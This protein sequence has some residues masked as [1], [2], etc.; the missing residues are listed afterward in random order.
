MPRIRSIKPDFC[1]SERIA[2]PTGLSIPCRLHFAM[3]WTYCDDEGRGVDNPRLIKAALWPLDDEITAVEVEA[4]QVELEAKGR[5]R[6]YEVDGR[7]CFVTTNFKEHQKPS[8]PQPSKLPEPPQ[9]GCTPPPEG[10]RNGS[11]KVPEGIVSDA[12]KA[13]LDADLG[14]L[15]DD[16]RNALGGLLP[17]VVGEKERVSRGEGS[18]TVPATA[19]VLALVVDLAEPPPAKPGA[20]FE[21]TTWDLFWQRWP[22]KVQKQNAR[23]AWCAVA[24]STGADIGIIEGLDRWLRHWQADAT[25]ERFIPHPD[26]WLRERRWLEQPPELTR[27]QGQ[28][29]A[30]AQ[31]RAD[32]VAAYAQAVGGPGPEAIQ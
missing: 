3:L 5:I 27:R 19:P 25:P 16:S 13:Q 6:R 11:G 23:K 21:Q 28:A 24:S 8:K 17:V 1:T 9:Q 26:R 22:R 31:A 20:G 12:E 2:G 14:S 15:P 18:V 4:W 32:V 30:N 7:R 29:D 10:S